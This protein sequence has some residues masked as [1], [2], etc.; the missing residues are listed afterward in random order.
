[1]AAEEAAEGEGQAVGGSVAAES[2]E[3]VDAAGGLKAAGGVEI[4]GE[5]ELVEANEADE[6][7]VEQ[8]GAGMAGSGDCFRLRGVFWA[9]VFGVFGRG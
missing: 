8:G 6:Q 4:G 5:G 9:S 3:G 7:A 1:M 2:F